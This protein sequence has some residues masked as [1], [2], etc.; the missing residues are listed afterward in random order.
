MAST[1]Q[2][3]HGWPEHFSRLM[4]AQLA[5][6]QNHAGHAE[7]MMKGKA[8]WMD[9]TTQA[10]LGLTARAELARATD[11]TIAGA[12]ISLGVGP[13]ISILI[14]LF[15]TAEYGKWLET[16]RGAAMGSRANMPTE[17]LEKRENVGD[18]AAIHPTADLIGPGY[19]RRTIALWASPG[20]MAS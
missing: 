13:T 12:A 6:A 15:H 1:S 2:L 16:L 5:L 9:R 10:R 20:G 3:G 7:A 4:A 19:Q 8:G 17:E 18:L 11:L 14:K